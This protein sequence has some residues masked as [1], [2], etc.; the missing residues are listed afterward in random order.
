M[1]GPI[2]CRAAGHRR[3]LAP[4]S[5]NNVGTRTFVNAMLLYNEFTKSSKLP[6]EDFCLQTRKNG[7][8][9]SFFRVPKV[10][11]VSPFLLFGTYPVEPTVG[12]IP[13][14]IRPVKHYYVIDW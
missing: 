4:R 6:S 1:R 13:S 3:Q 11:V 9:H 5:G 12:E 8:S 14:V 7:I 10:L 2:A